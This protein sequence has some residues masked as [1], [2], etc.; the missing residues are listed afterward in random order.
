MRTLFD[1][2]GKAAWSMA[3]AAVDVL[4]DRLA[5]GLVITKYEH[6]QGPLAKCEIYEAGHPV[7]DENSIKTKGQIEY[8]RAAYEWFGCSFLSL[9]LDVVYQAI[10][11]EEGSS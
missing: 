3:E 4:Q 5:K 9:A 1:T 2:S 8:E 10:L 7:L 11:S 6:S